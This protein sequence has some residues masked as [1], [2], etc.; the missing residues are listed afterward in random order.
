MATTRATVVKSYSRDLDRKLYGYSRDSDG[1]RYGYSREMF[2]CHLDVH[3]QKSEGGTGIRDI[4]V[5]FLEPC[6]KISNLIW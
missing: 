4:G 1:K 2:A 3:S 5:R 6:A